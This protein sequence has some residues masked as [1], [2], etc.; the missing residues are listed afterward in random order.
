MYFIMW[1]G[2]LIVRF[3]SFMMIVRLRTMM[4][5]IMRLR[6][7]MDFIVWLG[8]LVMGFWTMMNF[9]VWLGSLIVRFGTRMYFIMWL[10]TF[11]VRFR[12]RMYFINLQR[13]W[14][15]IVRFLRLMI[16]R[17]WRMILWFMWF[18]CMNVFG[19]VVL[20]IMRLG[21]W[22][23]MVFMMFGW[24]IIVVSFVMV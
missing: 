5:F 13:F 4:N 9:V 1:L 7:R 15:L 21:K 23:R 16:V 18:G 8:S 10:I 11:I 24:M 19:F 2:S 17:L 20:F 3:L 14:S 12:T 6:S 22:G